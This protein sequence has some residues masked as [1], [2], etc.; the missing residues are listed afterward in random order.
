MG[1]T[2]QI[3][4]ISCDRDF[5]KQESARNL[6]PI[7]HSSI[8]LFSKSYCCRYFTEDGER[9]RHCWKTRTKMSVICEALILA[10]SQHLFLR[11][12]LCGFRPMQRRSKRIKKEDEEAHCKQGMPIMPEPI[13]RCIISS[14]LSFHFVMFC[15]Y[16][17]KFWHGYEILF[18]L[19]AR[20]RKMENVSRAGCI[21]T[22]I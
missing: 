21:D 19:L 22:K 13:I 2:E 20:T 7:L 6:E 12:A 5:N 11:A 9:I 14:G 17:T 15:S 4:L 18:R 16:I 1:C 10:R 8:C 3:Y